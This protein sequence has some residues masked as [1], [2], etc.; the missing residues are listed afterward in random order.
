[1]KVEVTSSQS[2]ESTAQFV[3]DDIGTIPFAGRAMA[4]FAELSSNMKQNHQI[5]V[6]E[7]SDLEDAERL[8]LLYRYNSPKPDFLSGNLSVSGAALSLGFLPHRTQDVS[9][10]NLSDISLFENG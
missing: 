8:P 4:R 1:M 5:I 3:F 10:V 2:G 9:P 6:S 7:A